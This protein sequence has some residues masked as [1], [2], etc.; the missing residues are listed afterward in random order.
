MSSNLGPML[1]QSGILD[2]KQL[3]DS[4][5]QAKRRG[6]PLWQVLLDEKQVSEESLAEAFTQWLKVPRVRLASSAISAEA[7]K[8]IS[9]ELARRHLVMPVQVER[10]ML[11][12]AMVNPADYTAIQ[13]LQFAAGMSIKPVVASRAEIMDAIEAHYAPDEKVEDFL[14]NVADEGDLR[15]FEETEDVEVSDSNA[16][17]LP[18]VVKMCNLIIR[19]AIKAGAS[20]VHIEAALN[21]VQVRLRIDGVLRDYMQIPKWLHGPMVSR[22]KILAKLDIAERRVPQDGRIKVQ[23]QNKPV[24]MRIST[25]PTHFG[26]KVVM[27]VLGGSEVPSFA[28]LGFSEAQIQALQSATTQP[29][30]LILVTGPTGS[31]KS[32]TLYSVL[33][34]RRSPEVNIITVEDPIEYQL[35]GINQVQV[36]TKAGLTFA[37]ALRSILRQDPDIV[38]VGEIR[39][40]ETAEIAFHAAMTGHLVLSTL[41]TNSSLATIAR[42]LDLGIEAQAITSSINL[43]IA[44]R[45]ARRICKN[46]KERYEPDPALLARLRIEAGSMEFHRGAGCG[47]CGHTGYAGRVGIYEFLRMTPT[48]KE[49]INRKASDADLRKAAGIAGTRFLLEEAMDKVRNGITTLEE[50]LRVIQL[51]EDEIIRCPNCQSFINLDFSTCPYCLFALKNVCVSCGQELKLDWKICP[52]CNTRV[53]EQHMALPEKGRK[54]ASDGHPVPALEAGEETVIPE[55][56]APAAP[57]EAA[58][59]VAAGKAPAPKTPRILVVDDDDG[60]KTIVKKALRQLPMKVEVATASDGVEALEKIEKAQPDMVILDVMMPRMDGFTVCQKLREQVRTAFI[61]VMMLTAN[62]DENARTKGFMVGT[63][64]YVNKPFSVP[65]LNARVMRLLRRTYGL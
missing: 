4:I 46:C 24:D 6:V 7:L 47:N 23:V 35:Q 51:Q 14:A 41:H 59:A 25:L 17:Q 53:G 30:G 57:D 31:G 8:C 39:D 61:P 34:S 63:D 15:V 43:I 49:F 44:Q 27:R 37:A 55:A 26:E 45:L 9:E 36:N 20:D 40:L 54:P 13:D 16:A 56:P 22:L 3:E 2:K 60:I 11:V 52:Y 10:K 48:L 33:M 42:L 28:G 19:D 21:A 62:A 5:E 29:Q 64:D 38:L 1:L 65:D 58:A 12:L 32:T 18:P 50:V